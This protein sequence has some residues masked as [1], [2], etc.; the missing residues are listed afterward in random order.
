[1]DARDQ[2]CYRRRE[3]VLGHIREM[4]EMIV[5]R[6]AEEGAS[7]PIAPA[8]QEPAAKRDRERVNLPETI[9]AYH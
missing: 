4:A 3:G 2:T 1:M 8:D 9:D 7:V 6:L 5:E